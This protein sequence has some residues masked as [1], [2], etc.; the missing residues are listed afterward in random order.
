MIY[1]GIGSRETPP[2]V[3][4]FMEERARDWAELMHTLRSG[5]ARGAD[6][7]FEKG[8]ISGGGPLEIFYADRSR[9]GY[10]DNKDEDWTANL[11]Q[12]NVEAY[13][14]ETIKMAM[15]HAKEFH[16]NW[17]ACSPY[18]KKL[19]ARN[20]LIMLGER[21]NNPVDLVVCWTPNG[22]K[23]GGTAQALRIA[24]YMKIPIVKLGSSIYGLR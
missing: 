11:G 2:D 1:A 24:E 19:H 22:F 9:I 8:A 6:T 16:P 13:D 18:A 4:K 20:S 10:S 12:S 15:E 5:G 14:P 3:L 23:K 17:H 21:L 7:A